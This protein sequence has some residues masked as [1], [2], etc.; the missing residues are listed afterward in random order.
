MTIE[1]FDETLGHLI[2]VALPPNV[3]DDLPNNPSEV[4]DVLLKYCDEVRSV[5]FRLAQNE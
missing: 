3:S 1:Q 5:I 4:L 2:E